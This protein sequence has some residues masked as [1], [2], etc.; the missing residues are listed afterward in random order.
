MSTTNTG[1]KKLI[2]NLLQDE[3][4][5]GVHIAFGSPY[6]TRTG[7]P[8]DSMAHVDGVIIKPSIF[9]NDQMI[10]DKGRFYL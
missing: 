8:W 4:F 9:V 6:P 5:P 2:Y 1:L 3:K 7:A 10:M